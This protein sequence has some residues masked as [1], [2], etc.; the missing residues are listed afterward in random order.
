MQALDFLIAS[1]AT[2]RVAALLVREEGPY[3]LIARARGAMVRTVTGRA[4]ACFYCTSFWIALPAAFWLT[5]ATRR[6]PVVWLGLAGAAGLLERA[7]AARE[8]PALDLAEAER[9]NE[10]VR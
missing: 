3:A 4:L 5:G 2:W 10:E 1:L 8:T 9:L 6:W 7:T